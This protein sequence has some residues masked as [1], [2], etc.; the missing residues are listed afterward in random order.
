MC[1]SD[2]DGAIAIASRARVR[3]LDAL[4]RLALRDGATLRALGEA[5]VHGSLDAQR[6]IAEIFIRSGY[7]RPELAQVFRRHRLP[8]GDGKDLIDVLISRLEG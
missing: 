5:F 6:A 2:L 3:A 4:G 8:S 7:R 1:S